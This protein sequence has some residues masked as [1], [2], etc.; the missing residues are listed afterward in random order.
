MKYINKNPK[1]P[2]KLDS[3][4]TTGIFAPQGTKARKRDVRGFIFS[5][6]ESATVV[7]PNPSSIGEVF[8]TPKKFNDSTIANSI[9]I[10]GRRERSK[11]TTGII[12]LL[13]ISNKK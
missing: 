6:D 10:C 4:R 3:I 9:M 2:R 1:F 8:E 7:H 11:I 5:S 12:P 13:T